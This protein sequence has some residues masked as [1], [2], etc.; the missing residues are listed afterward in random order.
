[1]STPRRATASPG[2]TVAVA[3][4]G[5]RDSLALLHATV[6]AAIPCALQVV[7]LHVHHGLLAEADDWVASS[8]RLCARWQR[9]GWPVQ[10]RVTR[11]SGAPRKGDSIE[12]WARRGRYAALAAMAREVGASIV[13]LAQHRRDQAETVLLQA[14]RGAGPR[15]LAAMPRSIERDGLVWARPWLDQP[16]EAIEAYLR[17]YRLKAVDDP[18]NSDPAFARS[19]LRQQVLPTLVAAFPQVETTL[20]AL[21][22]RA[23]EADALMT[24]VAA[25]DIARCVD[26]G[27]LRVE[28]WQ[29]LSAAR[30]VNSLR[31]WLGTQLATV[32]ESLVERLMRELPARGIARW[33]AL[34]DR[35]LQ[36]HR[37]VL[38]MTDPVSLGGSAA[39]VIDLSTPGRHPVADWRGAF[40]VVAVASRGLSA[41]DLARARLAPRRGG[42]RFQA[43]P[44]GIARSL[45]K[46]FQAAGIAG[47][48]RG[49]PLVW[50]GDRLLFVPGLGID[51]RAWVADGMPQLA[52]EWVSAVG[53]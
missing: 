19:R 47:V 29:M 32:P 48:E 43:A 49:G 30:R 1:M 5:G 33:P 24:E 21:A 50:A 15:G 34:P 18:S 35:W 12:A 38:R 8:E 36:L 14:L 10:L 13:L 11:L 28:R 42:E 45:K 39:L 26:G 40:E 9:K 16:R 7:A 20:A 37:G 3:F 52:L 25:E 4:S 31:Q 46:Q 2:A 41:A 51:A 27:G 53:G 44:R 23:A 6:Q 22:R 17:R